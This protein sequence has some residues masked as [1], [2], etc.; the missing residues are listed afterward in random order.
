MGRGGLRAAYVSMAPLKNPMY[1]R[2]NIIVG[3][4]HGDCLYSP[5]LWKYN[6]FFYV[7]SHYRIFNSL[8]DRVDDL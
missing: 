2:D 6:F 1:I 3:S 5:T 8:I 7:E 4:F